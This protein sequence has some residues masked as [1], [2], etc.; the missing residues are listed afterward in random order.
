MKVVSPT[1]LSVLSFPSIIPCYH[2]C[3]HPSVT[4]HSD[5]DREGV[6]IFHFTPSLFRLLSRGSDLPFW[7]TVVSVMQKKKK[8]DFREN[9]QRQEILPGFMLGPGGWAKGIR[10]VRVVQRHD[11]G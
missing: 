8:T 1:A 9:T 3:L 4:Y 11:I 10:M 2:F 6:L 5:K 7:L